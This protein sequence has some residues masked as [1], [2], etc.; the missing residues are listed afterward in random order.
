[1][2]IYVI[3]LNKF[4]GDELCLFLDINQPEHPDHICPIR[5]RDVVKGHVVLCGK[6]EAPGGDLHVLIDLVG[7]EVENL[8][9]GQVGEAARGQGRNPIIQ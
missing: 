3:E 9:A 7:G 2:F 5:C 4:W 1:M 6:P 8:E